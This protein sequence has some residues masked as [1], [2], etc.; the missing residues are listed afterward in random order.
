M[1]IRGMIHK[2][3]GVKEPHELPSAMI[4]EVSEWD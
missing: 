4:R 1:S 3:F 2:I